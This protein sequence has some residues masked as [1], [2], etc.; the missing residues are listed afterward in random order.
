MGALMVIGQPRP[1]VRAFVDAVN[2]AIT[3][4]H[5]GHGLSAL[6]RSWLAFCLTA[7]LVTNAVCW[8]RFERASLGTYSLAALSWM[9]RHA[10]IPWEL[11]LVASVRVLLRHYG[12]TH[13]SL[14]VDDS[15]KQR[16]KSAK[17]IAYLHYLR[18]KGSGGCILGQSLVFLL[19]VTPKITIPMGFAFYMPAP[20][21]TAWYTQERL[22]K[23]QGI[24]RKHRPPKPPSN[25]QYPTKQELALC[26]LAQCKTHHPAL[27][28]HCIIADALYGS[29][30]FMD[31]A[32]ALF[33]GVQV[34][35]QLRSN[36]RVRVHKREL[37]VAD[38]FATH[39]GTPQQIRI[40]G[41]D[42]MV[43]IVG[44]ARLYVCAHHTK[45]FVIALKYDGEDTY[46]YVMAS[47]LSWRTLDIIHAHTLRW[48]VE[49]FVQDW[50]AYEGWDTL[51]KQPGEEGSR[52]SVI[53]SLLVDHCLFLHPAQHAQLIHNLP[54]YTVGSLRAQVQVECLVTVIEELVASVDPPAQLPRLNEALHE[55][56]TFERST[57]HLVQRQLGRLE[58]TPS[59]KYR[60]SE[61]MR[62]MPALST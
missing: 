7:I 51:A 15:D 28:V 33:G 35:S 43:A 20:E 25:P 3:A 48:L 22:L 50:K 45:R 12:I 2:T 60:A 61:V 21:L 39:P 19:L 8:A 11:L 24:P 34:I 30:A 32:S 57:K 54:A 44:S 10:K 36:Q 59:L 62:N 14:V 47:D 40:R 46:R 41:G 38:Y 42:E 5:P 17:K 53:L 56:F 52:R 1:F 31:G 55:V 23:Q 27:H 9:F 29:A 4:H 18:D 26:L 6:Q 58:P 37:H 13:G 16:A 49:V